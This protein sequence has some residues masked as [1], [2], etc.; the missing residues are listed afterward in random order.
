MGSHPSVAHCFKT[1]MLLETVHSFP[2]LQYLKNL[3]ETI[4]ITI[5]TGLLAQISY[6]VALIS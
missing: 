6:W 4:L 1:G 2:G 3:T 5:L